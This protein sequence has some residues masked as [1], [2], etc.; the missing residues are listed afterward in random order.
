VRKAKLF[1]ILVFVIVVL[2]YF[3]EEEITIPVPTLKQGEYLKVKSI[4]LVT[5]RWS[6]PYVYDWDSDGR[7]DLLVGY[8]M[9]KHGYVALFRNRGEKG[10]PV[11]DDPV[12]LRAGRDYID[13]P[14]DG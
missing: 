1:S 9:K 5:G 11:L 2:V 7:D 12:L 6:V 10:K 3:L 4:P 8:K 13:L 14:P